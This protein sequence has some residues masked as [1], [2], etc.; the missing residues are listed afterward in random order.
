VSSNLASSR[1]RAGALLV[2]ALFGCVSSGAREAA[3]P[4]RYAGSSTIGLFLQDAE[5]SWLGEL[6]IDTSGESAGGERAI[7]E[8]SADVGGAAREPA[9]DAVRGDVRAT[10][11]GRDAIAVVVADS[12]PVRELSRDALRAVFTGHTRNWK[13]LGGPDLPIRPLIV[14]ES[15]ATRAVFKAAILGDADYAG[16]EVVTPDPDLPRRVAAEP[17]AIGTISLAFLAEPSGVRPL[18]IDGQ[19]PTSTNFDYPI[20]RPLYLLWREGA[21]SARRFVDW[22][23]GEEGQRVLMRRF[24]GARVR[25]SL[26]PTAGAA[27]TG[28]LIVA[29]L[30]EERRDGDV[31]YF[32]HLPYEILTRDG[33]LVRRVANRRGDVDEKPAR[34]ELPPDTYLVRTAGP[35][36]DPVELF[37]TI[38]A[39]RELTVDV[40]SLVDRR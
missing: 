21:A 6:R 19:T 2:S 23:L 25:A 17:G 14:A 18:S 15:S 7:A 40:A 20:S 10:L 3:P 11:I 32:P 31:T 34:V 38:E 1:R 35:G 36:R 30:T 26:K 24:V 9:A 5:S 27:G 12:L 4:L 8:G 33:A 22:T 13:E 16:C 37:V 29:T 39:G 28:T